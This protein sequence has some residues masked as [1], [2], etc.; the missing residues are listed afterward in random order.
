MIKSTRQL[1]AEAMAVIETIPVLQAIQAFASDN[2]AFIDI[3]DWPELAQDGQIPG[4][5]HASRGTLEWLADPECARHNKVFASGKKLILYCAGGG[6]S[7]LATQRL[8]E[9]GFTDIAHIEGGFTAW[10]AKHGPVENIIPTR[11]SEPCR[12][13]ELC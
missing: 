7:A 8:Q 1:V 3:R 6:R 9:L 12:S 5:V 4:A 13:A 2:V 10:V 11:T